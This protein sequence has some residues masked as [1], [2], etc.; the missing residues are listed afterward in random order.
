MQAREFLAQRGVAFTE[1]NFVKD[2]LSVTELRGLAKRAG[3]AMQLVGP[4]KRA[5]VDGLPDGAILAWLLADPRRLR[6][7]IIDT[8]RELH[9]GFTKSVREALSQV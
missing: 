2:R 7:P 1:R 9:L 8:G 5:E 6:R 4:T 3:G